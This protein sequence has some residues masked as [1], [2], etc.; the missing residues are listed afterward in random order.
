MKIEIEELLEKR[1]ELFNETYDNEE[2]GIEEIYHR[3]WVEFDF[4][5]R[6]KLGKEYVTKIQS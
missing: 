4:W 1:E 3:C 2:V 5:L 6:D